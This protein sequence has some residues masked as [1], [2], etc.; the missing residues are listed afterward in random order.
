MNGLQLLYGLAMHLFVQ[1]TSQSTSEIATRHIKDA[2]ALLQAH[3][4][5]GS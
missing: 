2:F 4:R 1:A 5:G 3:C